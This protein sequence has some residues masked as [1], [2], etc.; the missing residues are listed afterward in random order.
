MPAADLDQFQTRL[1]AADRDLLRA[2]SARA[3]LPREPWPVWD[4]PAAGAPPLAELIY[5]VASAGSAMD[6]ATAEQ[7]NRNL[8][9][10]LRALQ[11]RAAELAEA[12]FVRQRPD[13]QAAL[14]IG[15]RARMEALLAD[16]PA[17]LR[18]LADVRAAAER[19]PGLPAETVGLLWREY[20][21]PWTR[22]IELAHLMDP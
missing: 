21:I 22:Q 9:A 2:L 12:K 3:G 18:R 6:L 5:A 14:E 17:D 1:R 15:D 8:G 10:A 11:A 19:A 7:A 4:G 16:L 20:V 13:S